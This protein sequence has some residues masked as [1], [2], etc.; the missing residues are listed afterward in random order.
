MKLEV[1]VKPDPA[2]V[3]VIANLDPPTTVKGI[4]S[5]LG[6]L[7]WYRDMIEDFATLSIPLTILIKKEVKFVWTEECKKAFDT[8]KQRLITHPVLRPRNYNLPFHLYCDASAV[9]VGSALCQTIEKKKKDHPIAYA[10]RQLSAAQRNYTTIEQ[11]CLAMGFLVKKFRHYLL[12]NPVVFFVDHM[13]LRYLV[14]KSDLSGRLARW[15]LLLTEFNN[16]IQYKPGKMHH[17]AN[18]LSRLSTKASPSSINKGFPTGGSLQYGRY[19]HGLRILRISLQLRSFQNIWT[20]MC[21]AKFES[22]VPILSFYQES[23]TDEVSMESLDD[24]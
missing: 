2:E 20:L 4:Q 6:H 3:E 22:T 11:E 24:V 21:D 17:Q 14:N 18:H 23:Y 12:M 5:A 7:N 1:E 10:S 8:L 19:P 9:A 16:T 15:V 13:A